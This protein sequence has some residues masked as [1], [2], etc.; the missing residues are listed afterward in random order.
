MI[1]RVSLFTGL[2]VGAAVSGGL[3][4]VSQPAALTCDRWAPTA[5]CATAPRRLATV[6]D[7]ANPEAVVYDPALDVY[8]V[9]N[10]N[11]TPGVK[12]GNGFISRIHSDGRV[13]SLHFI[14]GGH[15]GVTLNAP[16]GSRMHGD[17]LWVLDVDVLRGFNARTGASVAAIDFA[18][19]GALFLNDLAL[20]PD[21]DFYVTDTGI[22]AH[23]DGTMDNSG[24]NRIYHVG[25][26]RGISIAL[27]SPALASP[28]GIA[29]DPA[30]QRLVLAPFG[31]TAVQSWQP[32]GA[33][34]RNIAPGKGK[35]DGA[36]V[37]RDG[38][39]VVTSW[40]DSTVSTLERGQLVARIGPL[41]MTPADVSLDARHGR[42]GIVSLEA[43]RFELWTWPAR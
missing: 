40:N 30:G 15:G 21:G 27:E 32:G 31:G 28:D 38:S 6:N 7:L 11:G 19:L 16:M 12:D 20:G 14:R 37:E 2:L 5:T 43:N 26:D 3:P 13:D 8:F 25:R 42:A 22:R 4:A 35:F 10:V 29:W 1:G 9:S 36:E 23:P 39:I 24:P 41:S 33:A 18:P 17:T 34:P